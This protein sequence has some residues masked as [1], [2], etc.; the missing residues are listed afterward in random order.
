MPQQISCGASAGLFDL[1]C[2]CVCVC[3]VLGHVLPLTFTCFVI[4]VMLTHVRQES[5]KPV[6]LHPMTEKKKQAQQGSGLDGR[7]TLNVLDGMG[8]PSSLVFPF[9][10]LSN[11]DC[12]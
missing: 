1:C 10:L 9:G 4:F 3:L 6:F 5:C 12:N 11:N 8:V 2:V 7:A